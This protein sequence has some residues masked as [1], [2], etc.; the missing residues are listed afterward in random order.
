[1]LAAEFDRRKAL[2]A[3]GATLLTSSASLVALIFGLTVLVTGRDALLVNHLAVY[4][5]LA[6]LFAFVAAAIVGIFI[7]THLQDYTVVDEETLPSLVKDAA[8]WR[9]CPDLALRDSVAEKIRTLSSLRKA[10]GDKAKW[11]KVGMYIQLA[12]IAGLVISLVME[13]F[14]RLA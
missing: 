3:R 5:V 6:S 14:S 2:E 4:G 11:V 9:R 10:N 12:A 1:M 13:L 7:Q 8:K